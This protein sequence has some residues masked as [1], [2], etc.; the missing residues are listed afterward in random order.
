MPSPSSSGALLS[1]ELHN[2]PFLQ[3]CRREPTPYTPIW[4]MRQAGRYLPEYRQVRDRVS[5][6]QLCKTPELAAEVTVSAVERLGVDAAILFA[7]ILLILEPMGMDLEF[8]AGDGPVLHNPVRAAADV[9]ALREVMPE[10][11][12]A[13]VLQ[14]VAMARAQLKPHIPLIGFAG[15]PFTLASY[16]L[17]GGGSRNYIHTKTFMYTQPQTWHTLMT[18]LSRNL[19]RYLNSQIS[20][21]VQAVQL[22]DSWVG[23]LS[24][25]DYRSFVLP[26]TQAVFANL[27]PGIPAIHFGTG[28]GAWLECMQ[29][30][31][32]DV[33]GIDFRV[34]LDQAWRRLGDV[35]LQGNL[36]PVVLYADQAYVQQ[37][38]QR[39]LQQAAGRP[40]HIFNLGH[41]L[42]P[43]TPVDNVLALV[44]AVHT[45]SARGRESGN[46]V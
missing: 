7:D 31:G 30:A 35:G 38:A 39:I 26:Y 40:G 17:E 14:T 18:L 16:M 27:P 41:G 29:E 42:L 44:D 4:L 22:F 2:S 33:I 46:R 43:T 10:E 34:E 13:F 12:L 23:N 45:L 15:A 9:E 24:P 21:G 37:C 3:A 28:T 11:S 32:G 19:V 25:E 8:A 36:D 20:A 6:L 5:F 1:P